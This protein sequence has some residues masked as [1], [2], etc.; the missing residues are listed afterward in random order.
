MLVMV[1]SSMKPPFTDI[2]VPVDVLGPFVS[3]SAAMIIRFIPITNKI[4]E[5]LQTVVIP[6]SSLCHSVV[7][8]PIVNLRD[9]MSN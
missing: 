7:K 6:L 5:I 1:I 4:N 2:L 8:H 9:I 3:F